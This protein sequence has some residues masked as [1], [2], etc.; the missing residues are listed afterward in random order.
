MIESKDGVVYEHTLTTTGPIPQG[1]HQFSHCQTYKLVSFDATW[2]N[3]LG[4]AGLF[5]LRSGPRL[6]EAFCGA[7]P[8][9]L[10][11][12]GWQDRRSCLDGG[13]RTQRSPTDVR[14]GEKA[15]PRRR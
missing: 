10:L 5:T 14:F 13:W 4:N 2:R 6:V 1:C 12:I 11:A 8:R 15:R 9:E 7:Q 3:E